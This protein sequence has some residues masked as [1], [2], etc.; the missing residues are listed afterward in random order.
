MKLN[1][2]A[3]EKN[4][5]F[6]FMFYIS[7]EG[8]KF[9]CFDEMTDKKTV[10]GTFKA[11]TEKLGFTWAKGVQQAGR[12]DAK[13]SANENILYVSSLYSGN[14]Q[15]LKKEFNKNSEFLKIKEIAKTFP[16]LE[17]PELI[18]K[19][20]YIYSYPENKIKNSLEE[21]EKRCREHSGTRNMSKFTDSKGLGLK[22][23]E[24]TVLITYSEGKLNFIG[25]SFMPK[26]V[27][28]MA[29]YILNGTVTVLPGKYLTMEKSYL[30]EKLK[31]MLITPNNDILDKNKIEEDITLSPE[32]KLE[33]QF[34]IHSV[35]KVERIGDSALIFYVKK[36]KKT[37]FVGKNGN[38][39]KKLKKKYGNIVVREME[40]FW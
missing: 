14:L 1:L 19:R 40:K 21:I 3:L 26:Q 25:N 17:F 36:G 35:L 28:I 32:E 20:E 7:Y 16:N 2:R 9:H 37:D 13:V 11:I 24:R 31:N 22:E 5:K 27:R 38:V 39:I 33:I 6:G 30:K 8:T 29:S 34:L 18:E 4:E 10:K 12:T 23:H 15:N